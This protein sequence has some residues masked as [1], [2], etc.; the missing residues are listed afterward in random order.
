VQ[1]PG[2]Y[3]K[4]F[5]DP[6]MECKKC[7]SRF[8]ADQEIS[9]CEQCG[10]KD[11]TEAKQFNLMFKTFIGPT[12]DESA[13]AFFRPETAQ[14][15]FVNFKNVL[16]TSRK[17]LPFGIAQIGK[18]FR[19]EITPGNFIF[20]TREFEQMEIEYFIPP[21]KNDKDWKKYFEEW[22]KEMSVWME[23]VL[24]LAKIQL[25]HTKHHFILGGLNDK[26]ERLAMAIARS[27]SSLAYRPRYWAKQVLEKTNTGSKYALIKQAKLDYTREVYRVDD[28]GKIE[29]IATD[30][31]SHRAE[32]IISYYYDRRY[33]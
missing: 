20:R 31:S 15:M 1:A 19:N 3:L 29:M 25:K 28:T 4:E 27:G 18:A 33:F 13:V 21:P 14:G 9:T 26:R 2:I 12:E 11:F 23:E 10:G 30:V 17:T 7:H 32:R 8:S 6:L 24:G 16:E 5:S 22:R